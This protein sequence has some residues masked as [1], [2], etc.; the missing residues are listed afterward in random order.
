M[1]NQQAAPATEYCCSLTVHIFYLFPPNEAVSRRLSLEKFAWN[2]DYLYHAPVTMNEINL[3]AA[4]T[5][6]AIT[7]NGCLSVISIFFFR[8]GSCVAV[9]WSYFVCFSNLHNYGFTLCLEQLYFKV[10]G[11]LLT[12]SMDYALHKCWLVASYFKLL[13]RILYEG[14]KAAGFFNW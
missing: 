1:S 5:C 8:E 2:S 10:K 14:V 7:Y 4:K 11:K 6:S 13:K 9:C 12:Y 3:V